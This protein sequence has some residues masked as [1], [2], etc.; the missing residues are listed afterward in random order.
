MAGVEGAKDKTVGQRGVA[1]V[2]I[3]LASPDS[4]VANET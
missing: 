3:E 1:I 2:S 4:I